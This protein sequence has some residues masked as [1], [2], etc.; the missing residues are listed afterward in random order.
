MLNWKIKWVTYS[1][2]VIDCYVITHIN[3]PHKNCYHTDINKNIQ[4]PCQKNN[5]KFVR[6]A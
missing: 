3:L 5:T 2:G 6:I 4:I 1:H